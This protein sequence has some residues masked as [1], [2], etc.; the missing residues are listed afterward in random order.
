VRLSLEIDGH[1]PAQPPGLPDDPVYQHV[2]TALA[3]AAKSLRAKDLCHALDQ[4]L[5][6][7]NIGGMRSRLKRLVARGLIAETEP[8][9]FG[10][11]HQDRCTA[12]AQSA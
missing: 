8:G 6:P 9:L 11:D 12:S 1:E 10:L 4:G 7:K 2:V 3:D 5:E